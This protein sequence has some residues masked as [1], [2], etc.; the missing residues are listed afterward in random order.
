M[1][2][3]NRIKPFHLKRLMRINDAFQ[4]RFQMRIKWDNHDAHFWNA[5]DA[6]LIR[7]P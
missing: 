3:W 6:D 2:I 7:F 1:R 4:M 5:S